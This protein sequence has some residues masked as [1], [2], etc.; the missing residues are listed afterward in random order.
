MEQGTAVP[1]QPAMCS[2]A[3]VPYSYLPRGTYGSVEHPAPSLEARCAAPHIAR[4]GSN[5][6]AAK[7]A[8]AFARRSR[9]VSIV[10]GRQRGPA[11]TPLTGRSGRQPQHSDWVLHRR[12]GQNR[13]KQLRGLLEAALPEPQDA[14]VKQ[15][16]RG[17]RLD[18]QSLCEVSQSGRDIGILKML[19]AAMGQGLGEEW[20]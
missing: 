8:A 5:S 12:Q 2:I 7:Y 14:F 4:C 13:A 11:V 16:Q 3:S 6:R 20:I 15:C 19:S 17:A 1:S 9:T 18:F 10:A